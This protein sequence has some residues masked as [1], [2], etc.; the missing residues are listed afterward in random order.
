MAATVELLHFARAS[1]GLRIEQTAAFCADASGEATIRELI[2]A[3]QID[4][5]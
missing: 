4:T 5:M 2:P 3:D 1:S